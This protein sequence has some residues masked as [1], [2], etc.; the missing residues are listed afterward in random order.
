MPFAA[1]YEEPEAGRPNAR[2]MLNHPALSVH[3]VSCFVI[4]LTGQLQVIHNLQRAMGI[5]CFLPSSS[6]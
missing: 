1:C 6:F 4:V 3:C 2:V 5:E